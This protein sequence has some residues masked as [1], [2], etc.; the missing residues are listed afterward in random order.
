MREGWNN[1]HIITVDGQDNVYEDGGIIYENE[2]ITH[3]GS[4]AYIEEAA[5][6]TGL[7][8]RDGKGKYLFPGLV[9]THTHL[10]QDI[11]KGMGSDLSLE[12]WFP[13]SMAPAGAVLKGRHVAAGVGLGLA[14]AIRCGVTTVADYMQLQPVRGLGKLE[15]DIAKKMGV[16]MV[17]GRGYRDIGKKE[18]V[19]RP[20]DVFADITA[21]KEEFE[22]DGMYRI[23][24]APA[25]GWGASLKLLKATRAYADRYHTRVMMHMFETGTDDHISRE[26]N[27]MPAIKHYEESGL[28]GPDL[29]AVHSVAV[30]APELEK[31][32]EYKV[33]V[34]YNPIANM[35][36]ASGV[37]PVKEML[38]S[39]IVV[40]IGTD[41]AGS[42]ND[43][44]ML[45]AM[46]FGALLQKTFHKDPQ[47]MTAGQM[48]RMATIE[49]ARALGMEDL[50][51]SIEEGK[52]ADFFLFDP[53]KSVKS[54]PVHDI[55]ATLI[56]SGDHRAVD[57]VVIN[58]R[59]VMEGGEFL[60]WDEH[61]ILKQAQLMADDLKR[62][63]KENTK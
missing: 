58:G 50:T 14:E 41:G 55:V 11:M 43:N 45:E 33:S 13:K 25:A 49:G 42:N 39:G 2:V 40:G 53:S 54:C 35:Y 21:L 31:Y 16:R 56:Y 59:S 18:L 60:L 44:D 57:T 24:L 46:K 3:V 30:G 15:L 10:Y 62:C 47:A 20:E 48:L 23:W 26:R 27:G 22:G 7:Y 5:E 52:K 19:E 28:L 12:D 51:G 6:K 1:L 37:A 8:L 32:V 29:L 61:E 34:S 63:M 17:Y 38:T 4:R 9:N 36:L